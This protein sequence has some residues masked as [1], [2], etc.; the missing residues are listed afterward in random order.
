[1]K[2]DGRNGIFRRSLDIDFYCFAAF[3]YVIS[4]CFMFHH[5]VQ[6]LYPIMA[7]SMTLF[8]YIMRV[9]S[10]LFSSRSMS[11][12]VCDTDVT[13]RRLLSIRKEAGTLTRTTEECLRICGV[14]DCKGV[15]FDKGF[16]SFHEFVVK[17][18]SNKTCILH[19]EVNNS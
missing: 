3:F 12:G 5:I 1:M 6:V 14:S 7:L 18:T 19:S 8:V 2:S 17:Y 9:Y 15:C 13:N 11:D 10:L 16:V 4:H